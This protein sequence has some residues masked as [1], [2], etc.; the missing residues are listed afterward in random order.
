[1]RRRKTREKEDEEEAKGKKGDEEKTAKC[2]VT[3]AKR[4]PSDAKRAPNDAKRAP[5]VTGKDGRETG[6][7]VGEESGKL[8]KG[9]VGDRSGSKEGSQGGE[10]WVLEKGIPLPGSEKEI[11]EGGSHMAKK[12]R[13]EIPSNS[14]SE[15]AKDV[16]SPMEGPSAPDVLSKSP[17]EGEK[18]LSEGVSNVLSPI[19][20]PYVQLPGEVCVFFNRGKCKF[21]TGSNAKAETPG[22]C[23]FPHKCW[24]CGGLYHGAHQCLHNTAAGEE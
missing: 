1:V 15:G 21:P 16:K 6:R 9:V 13:V 24:I 7:G 17:L 22:K 23:R 10:K 5:R 8:V 2:S 19:K 14:P 3:D 12:A 11:T 20:V 4:S 18:G